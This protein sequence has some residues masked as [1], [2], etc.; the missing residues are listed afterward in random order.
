MSRVK[1]VCN[2]ESKDKGYCVWKKFDDNDNLIDHG[3]IN[4]VVDKDGHIA[5]EKIEATSDKARK[6]V[7]QLAK[8]E[9]GK[10][11]IIK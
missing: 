2:K 1:E 10:R 9:F 4:V 8:E 11:S 6:K 3:R 5:S 7:K